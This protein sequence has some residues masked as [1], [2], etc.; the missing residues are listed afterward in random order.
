MATLYILESQ[1]FYKIGYA[2]K[3]NSRLSSI[4]TGNPFD[5]NVVL[6]FEDNNPIEI[7][8]YLHNKFKEKRH[9]WEWFSL[10]KNDIDE[11]IKESIEWFWR[12]KKSFNKFILPTRKYIILGKS[13]DI[14]ADKVWDDYKYIAYISSVLWFDNV[15]NITRFRDKIAISNQAFYALK[16]RLIDKWVIKQI[17]KEFFLNPFIWVKAE[18]ISY[19]LSQEFKE[20]NATLYWIT[21]L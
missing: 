2:E 15:I 1:W 13:Q 9:K 5:I 20:I 10:L 14:V 3:F 19:N 4:K 18:T 12:I 8:R 17:W 6:K 7:E 11:I 21:E 16:K